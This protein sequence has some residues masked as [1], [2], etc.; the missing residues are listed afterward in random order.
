MG[1]DDHA[2]ALLQLRHDPLLEEREDAQR[3][4]LEAFAAGRGD[5]VGALPEM[6]L[7][8]APALARL[9]LVDA[10]Q[11]AIIA[12]VE[13]RGLDGRDFVLAELARG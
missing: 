11:L 8:G 13:R 3:G 1:D 5:V 6:H 10:D 7:L 2:L 4:V 9:F 12:L